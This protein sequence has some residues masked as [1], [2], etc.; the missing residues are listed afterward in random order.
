MASGNG[1]IK[2]QVPKKKSKKT[3]ANE[4]KG[5]KGKYTKTKQKANVYLEQALTKAIQAQQKCTE[6][7]VAQ[8]N[9][10]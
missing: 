9:S 6:V 2:S 7:G 3:I 10:G 8:F 1:K 5:N 4:K